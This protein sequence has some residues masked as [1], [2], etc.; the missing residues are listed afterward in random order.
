M[1]LLILQVLPFLT[2]HITE[3]QQQK[4]L[5]KNKFQNE[6]N[7]SLKFWYYKQW[8]NNLTSSA[9]CVWLRYPFQCAQVF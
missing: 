6:K 9:H 5:N 1:Q 3:Q 7:K 8:G 4:I 2:T